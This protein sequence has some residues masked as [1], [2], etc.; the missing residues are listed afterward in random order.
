MRQARGVVI[1]LEDT[2]RV[3]VTGKTYD[4][5]K[6]VGGLDKHIQVLKTTAKRNLRQA[7][8]DYLTSITHSTWILENVHALWGVLGR[9]CHLPFWGQISTL[10]DIYFARSINLQLGDELLSMR[11]FVWTLDWYKKLFEQEVPQN[12]VYDSQL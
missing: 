4:T 2:E 11:T 8:V 6:L 3:Q 10:Q 7:V 5:L 9:L 1:W 12:C